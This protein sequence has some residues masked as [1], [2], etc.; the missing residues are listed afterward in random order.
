MEPQVSIHIPFHVEPITDWQIFFKDGEGFLRTAERAY[1][2]KKKVFTP[3]VLYNLLAM[4]IEKFSMAILMHQGALPYNHTMG[5]LVESLE[6][7][8]PGEF[9][10]LK[11]KI[12]ALDAFQEICEIDTF[13]IIPPTLEQIATI[14]TITTDFHHLVKT[15][16][17]ADLE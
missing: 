17:A 13:T 16:L 2:L 5:D 6:L 12:L 7:T 1:T 15:R 11:K 8:F 9:E 10:T 14:L 3:E 4:A